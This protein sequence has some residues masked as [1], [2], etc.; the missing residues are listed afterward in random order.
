MNL[1]TLK[2]QT[3]QEIERCNKSGHNQD[4]REKLQAKLSTIN[5]IIEIIKSLKSVKC[6]GVDEEFI[7]GSNW[8]NNLWEN[9]I[10][11]ELLEVEKELTEMENTM[12][13][14]SEWDTGFDCAIRNI[15]T[16][17]NKLKA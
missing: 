16:K 9:K 13:G 17:L 4:Y 11:Q 14:N 3:E 7:K 8:C 2:K 1:Q 6:S 10:K 12:H 5:E 15:R